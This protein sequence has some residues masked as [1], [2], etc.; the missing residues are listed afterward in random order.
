MM[1]VVRGVSRRSTSAGSRPRVRVLDVREDRSRAHAEDG[2]GGGDEGER[3][4]DH[5]LARADAQR[6][7]GQLQGV[8]A[9]GGQQHAVGAE[10]LGEA[11][12]HAAADG[13]VAGQTSLEGPLHRLGLSL[14]Q[15]GPV[16]RNRS[17]CPRRPHFRAYA[18]MRRRG[19]PG[20]PRG[21]GASRSRSLRPGPAVSASAGRGFP[22]D[23]R[24]SRRRSG[25]SA[26]CSP[27]ASSSFAICPPTTRPST[28]LPPGPSARGRGPCGTPWP[29]GGSRSCSS[30]R[31]TWSSSSPVGDRRPSGWAW[32]STSSWRSWG[33]RSS[34]G[35][36]AWDRSRPGWSGRSTA[37]GGC[38]LS[39]VNLM[40]LFQGVAWAPF[41]A[42]A[43]GSA[44]ERPTGRRIALL[45]VLLGLQVSTLGVE[46][47]LQTGL[48]ST[49][50]VSRRAFWSDRRPGGPRRGGRGPGAAPGRPRGARGPVLVE[51][52]ARAQ[53]FSSRGG[54]GLLC[55]PRRSRRDD[56]PSLLGRSSLLHRPRLLG[57]RLLPLGIP[58]LHLP[59]CRPT[60]A[61]GGG[62]VPDGAPAVAPG[63]RRRDPGPGALR[64]A[65]PAPGGASPSP[66]AAP[67][68][69]CFSPTFRWPCSPAS[70]WSAP[71]VSTVARWRRSALASCCPGS[72]FS[73]QPRGGPP[74][75]GR[76]RSAGPLAPPLLDPRGLV[77]ARAC[78]RRCG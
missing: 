20:P 32:P 30:T 76:P 44:A 65:G 74:A 10:V 3:R 64:P 54:S 23:L 12:L 48:E 71:S 68:S 60:G 66:S 49:L 73:S 11:L 42:W 8:G 47:V 36:S 75:R 27:V 46:I 41:V 18:S 5:L 6:Q 58:L 52:T 57:P 51:G 37:S 40:P 31:W 78:G 53:G 45:A 70:A 14:V 72:P 25:C 29:T 67:R 13:T 16:K 4:T 77:A 34:R 9:R 24:T 59:V 17:T 1:A 62:T 2:V 56:P 69:C 35:P 63:G 38:C 19:A 50:L 39:E 61:A 28:P 7:Q 33:A 22:S 55:A 21:E 15:P 43:L 26:G